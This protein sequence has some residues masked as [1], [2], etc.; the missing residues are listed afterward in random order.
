MTITT[1]PAPENCDRVLVEALLDLASSADPTEALG[2]SVA[3]VTFA[4][5]MLVFVVGLEDAAS[6]PILSVA[7]PVS[8]RYLVIGPDSTALA[9]LDAALQGG[10]VEFQRINEG[11]NASNLR[12]ALDQADA[13]FSN[14]HEAYEARILEIP[15]IYTSSVWISGAHKNIFIP[16]LDD[17][18]L[19]GGEP[20][21]QQDF[22]DAVR[23][24]AKAQLALLTEQRK[25]G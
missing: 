15:A 20:S 24:R 14:T 3:E 2:G 23:Q 4:K 18:R 10:S 6:R 25:N 16:Y 9:D 22:L 8:W 5:P 12:T 17:V 13:L 21:V 7:R 1:S 11:K 19:A